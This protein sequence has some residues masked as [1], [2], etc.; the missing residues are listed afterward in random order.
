MSAAPRAAVS[1]YHHLYRRAEQRG[2]SDGHIALEL[3]I[4]DPG[5]FFFPCRDNRAATFPLPAAALLTRLLAWKP[6][7]KPQHRL[8][9]RYLNPYFTTVV[10]LINEISYGVTWSFCQRGPRTTPTSTPVPWLPTSTLSLAT[11][12]PTPHID[13]AFS[14]SLLLG[15]WAHHSRILALQ[16]LSHTVQGAGVPKVRPSKNEKCNSRCRLS[17]LRKL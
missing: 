11:H 15:F 7:R 14:P 5:D 8:T 4:W 12:H 2:R 1:P 6:R 10:S 3:V 13:T 16:P 17:D 9:P